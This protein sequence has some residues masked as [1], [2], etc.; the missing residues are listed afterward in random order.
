MSGRRK[1]GTKA[2]AMSAEPFGFEASQWEAI[3][4]APFLVFRCVAGADSL[5]DRG[6]WA[7]LVEL[8]NES[9]DH[10]DELVAALMEDLADELEEHDLGSLG[11]PLEGL[12]RVASLLNPRPDGAVSVKRTLLNFG[13][14]VAQASG[15][16]LTRAV[17]P[18][19]APFAWIRSGGTSGMERAALDSAAEALGLV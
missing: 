16:Q 13:E 3:K 17:A 4:L 15:A 19:A 11:D 7:T 10:E 9:V 14:V 1:T 12:R 5:I 6:E 18:G 8:V 2:G